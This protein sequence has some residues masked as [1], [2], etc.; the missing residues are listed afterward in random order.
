MDRPGGYQHHDEFACDVVVV[1]LGVSLDSLPLCGLDL[2]CRLRSAAGLNATLSED[3]ADRRVG[4]LSAQLG[5]SCGTKFVDYPMPL[6]GTQGRGAPA[7]KCHSVETGFFWVHATSITN[8][9][10][11]S[12]EFSTNPRRL[13]TAERDKLSRPRL[14]WTFFIQE[15]DEGWRTVYA[16][17]HNHNKYDLFYID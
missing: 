6:T 15:I 9:T 13:A 5:Q 10:C 14:S 1:P 16:T 2:A 3:A 4:E 8:T 12:S 7:I 11:T 17:S